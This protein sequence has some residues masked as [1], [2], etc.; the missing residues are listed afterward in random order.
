MGAKNEA[1]NPTKANLPSRFSVRILLLIVLLLLQQV[2]CNR[3]ANTVFLL[4]FNGM[5]FNVANERRPYGKTVK[6]TDMRT[7]LWEQ[8]ENEKLG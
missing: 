8:N 2:L 4:I 5:G 1:K 6:K 3:G 7:R